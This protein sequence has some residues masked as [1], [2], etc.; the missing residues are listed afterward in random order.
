[1]S[2]GLG[3]SL[4]DA[5]VTAQTTSNPSPGVDIIVRKNPG[6]GWPIIV[7][8]SDRDGR[9]SGTV[10]ADTREVRLEANTAMGDVSTTR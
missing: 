6:P 5:P 3:L 8:Q 10:D 4:L 2:A 9:F 1:M 7:G